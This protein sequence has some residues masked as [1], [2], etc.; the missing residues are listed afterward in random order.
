MLS[1]GA[2]AARRVALRI[3]ALSLLALFL[4]PGMT[5]AAS[6]ASEPAANAS[7][8]DLKALSK[9]LSND[10]DRGQFLKTLNALIAARDAQSKTAAAAASKT[11]IGQLQ[12]AMDSIGTEG[13]KSL[14]LMKA[15]PANFRLLSDQ[16]K[17]PGT[18]ADYEVVALKVLSVLAIAILAESIVRSLLQ[19]SRWRPFGAETRRGLMGGL[20]VLLRLGVNAIPIL[21][22]AGIA[23]ALMSTVPADS[24]ARPIAS[25]WIEANVIERII[26]VVSMALFVPR[27]PVPAPFAFPDGEDARIVGRIRW[28]ARIGCYGWAIGQTM[29]WLG[30]P[31]ESYMLVLRLVALVFTGVAIQFVLRSRRAVAMAIAGN[32]A[33]EPR[34]T[35]ARASIQRLRRSVADIWHIVAIIYLVGSFSVLMV[36]AQG[37][38][39]YVLEDTAI[40]IAILV[41][42]RLLANAVTHYVTDPP[43]AKAQ[44]DVPANAR[45]MR[46]ERYRRW[47][48]LI[49][50]LAITTAAGAGILGT[51]GANVSTWFA[52]GLGAALLAIAT[53]IGI[54]LGI[55]VVTWE[56]TSA[57]IERALDRREREAL[58]HGRPSRARTLLPLLRNALFITLLILVALV[59]MG[60]LGLNTGPL[61]AGASVVGV[62][63]GLGAQQLVKDV[64]TGLV[65]LV[66]NQIAVGDSINLGNTQMGYPQLGIVEAISLRTI[67][68]R[69][70]DGALHTIPFSQVNAVIN[71]SRDYAYYQVSVTV[72]AD[73]EVEAVTTVLRQA[74]DDLVAEKQIGSAVAAPIEIRGVE[75]I[76]PTSYTIRA[77]LKTSPLKQWDVGRAFNQLLHAR[78]V[79]A[80]IK[81][82]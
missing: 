71:F 64:V 53:H 38:F 75:S 9:T 25:A 16:F 79:Q 69:D 27:P 70:D 63:L 15:L 72:P 82:A 78:L 80:G 23:L 61:I 32:P 73:Q 5:R 52:T 13:T 2:N 46:T 34:N 14:S 50:R 60:E 68:L 12:R 48:G 77:R 81:L 19:R 37:G 67:Q 47:I 76:G 49:L 55:A 4:L 31:D 20:L 66:E 41:C 35:V 54:I 17:D 29:L 11:P 40:S 36:R 21:F 62:A 30:A 28:L 44:P 51:W 39:L 74:A 45:R 57:S 8:D 6:A 18:R 58:V 24:D 42:A 65:M 33:S 22:F 3:V 26:V 7:T 10:V 1:G 59:I 43:A 56:I